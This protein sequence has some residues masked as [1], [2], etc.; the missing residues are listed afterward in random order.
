[1]LHIHRLTSVDEVDRQ[2]A[3]PLIS[4]LQRRPDTVLGLATGGTPI[5]LY[6]E[7]IAAYTRGEI[8]FAQAVTFNLDEYIGLSSEH[9]QSY[10]YYMEQN[11]FAHIDLPRERA[12][13][14]NGAT[15]DLALACERYEQQ[16][17]SYGYPDVQVLGIGH[18]GHIA[19]NEPADELQADTHVVQLTDTTIAANAR[20]FTNPQEVPRQAITMGIASIMKAKTIV[21]IAKGSD[22]AAIIREAL[23]GP[24]RTQCPASL[25]QL[26]PDLHVFVDS[27][28]GSELP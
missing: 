23:F 5:G 12:F 16:L 17:E 19:F 21:L 27:E 6:R 28:A 24:I 2:A 3:G 26:H 1:M 25:L 10:R 18:N 4:A 22:K 14:P 9:P 7:L 11:L 20:F 8:S 13:L 15:S